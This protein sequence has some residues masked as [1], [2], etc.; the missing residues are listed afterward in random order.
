MT[1]FGT[2]CVPIGASPTDECTSD[3]KAPLAHLTASC[4]SYIFNYLGLHWNTSGDHNFASLSSAR[5]ALYWH[6]YLPDGGNDVAEL[7]LPQAFS[8]QGIN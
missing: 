2:R 6:P 4:A 3:G 8:S 1:V 5:L 7:R